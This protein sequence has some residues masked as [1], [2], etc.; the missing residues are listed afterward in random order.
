[1]H[2]KLFYQGVIFLVFLIF[3]QC[4]NQEENVKTEKK[5]YFPNSHNVLEHG[6]IISK[7]VSYLLII[8]VYLLYFYQDPSTDTCRSSSNI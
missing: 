4:E 6:R 3:T 5:Q 2:Q 7:P 8:F 1:M